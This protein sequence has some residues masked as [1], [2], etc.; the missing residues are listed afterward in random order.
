[1]HAIR[2]LLS[3]KDKQRK[4]TNLLG[5]QNKD[6]EQENSCYPVEDERTMIKALM[7]SV[8]AMYMVNQDNKRHDANTAIRTR[9]HQCF[10]LTQPLANSENQKCE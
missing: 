8:H 9:G 10:T 5:N 1:V 4:F 3:E 7:I 6:K 2:S